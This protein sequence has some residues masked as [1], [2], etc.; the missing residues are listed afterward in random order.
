[1]KTDHELQL[2]LAKML[3]E[4]IRISKRHGLVWIKENAK[5]EE[6][7]MLHICWLIEQGLTPKQREK[8]IDAILAPDDERIPYKELWTYLHASWQQRAAA[9]IATKGEK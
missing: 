1:M 9:L 6:T 2:A 8:Y 7:E 4:Q 3:P 5:V